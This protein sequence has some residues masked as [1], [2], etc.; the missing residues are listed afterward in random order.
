MKKKLENKKLVGIQRYY[1]RTR[2]NQYGNCYYVEPREDC[3]LDILNRDDRFVILSFDK[4]DG[5]IVINNKRYYL[6]KYNAIRCTDKT[7]NRVAI[8]DL[9]ELES[10]K[11]YDYDNKFKHQYTTEFANFD[12]LRSLAK[13]QYE[14]NGSPYIKQRAIYNRK[15]GKCKY[16]YEPSCDRRVAIA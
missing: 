9:D 13:M 2:Q 15:T 7:E 5:Y 16:L 1:Q 3:P 8:I 10:D 6:S 12:E 11:S 14:V 4:R